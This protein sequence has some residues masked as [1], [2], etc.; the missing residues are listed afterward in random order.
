MVK[1]E[2]MRRGTKGANGIPEIYAPASPAIKPEEAK[3]RG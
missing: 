2:K 3:G 1:L